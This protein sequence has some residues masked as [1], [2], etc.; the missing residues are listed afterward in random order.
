MAAD[1]FDALGPAMARIG[2][3]I[4][5]T[6]GGRPE[7]I[8]L[9]VEIGDGWVDTSLFRNEGN[10]VVYYWGSHEL[11]DLVMDAW[12]LE[13]ADKRWTAMHYTIEGGKFDAA[14]EFDNLEGSTESTSERRDRILH[15]RYGNKPIVYPP[16]RG[17]SMEL[18]AP[19]Q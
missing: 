18:D 5:G 11:P 13:P 10:R 3:N 6:I 19:R 14:F 8:Y 12:C 7:G 17:H 1:H 16:L 9:Y 2:E 4:Y 15:A